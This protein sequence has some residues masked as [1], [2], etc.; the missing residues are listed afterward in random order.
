MKSFHIYLAAPVVAPSRFASDYSTEEKERLRNQFKPI[1]ERYQRQNRLA[2]YGI[3]GFM[4]FILLALLLPKI[5]F[6]WILGPALVCWLVGAITL[7]AL[8]KLTCPGCSNP[9]EHA[10]GPYCPE[11][12][13]DQLRKGSF[14][15]A[16]HCGACNKTM[17]HRRGRRYKI[18]ACTHCGLPLDE[19][20]V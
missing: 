15:R 18:R 3:I 1:M 14:F 12:G 17:V 5:L 13:S 10:F 19:T 2:M 6:P 9:L 16:P 11:C 8:P 7:G 4:G 20:G